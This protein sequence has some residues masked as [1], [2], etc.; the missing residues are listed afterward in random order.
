MK[1]L[2]FA[3][4][5]LTLNSFGQDPAPTVIDQNVSA[6]FPGNVRIKDAGEQKTYTSAII[7][8]F[9]IL[10]KSDQQKMPV[11]VVNES[12]LYEYY[13]GFAIGIAKTL[14]GE[15]L[16]QSDMISSGLLMSQFRCRG[17]VNGKSQIIS[18]SLVFVK[19]NIYTILSWP[20]DKNTPEFEQERDKII[21]SIKFNP[22]LTEAD[23]YTKT[24]TLAT[25]AYGMVAKGFAMLILFG[26]FSVVAW[27]IYR[28]RSSVDQ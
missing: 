14:H 11:P 7:D 1:H 27:L 19:K 21:S 18:G 25:T 8:G 23:Q 12:D 28:Q 22:A 2:A 6:N 13:K 9:V 16:M 5:L 17:I 15:V 24:T 26:A 10:V 4:L 3:V 20:A